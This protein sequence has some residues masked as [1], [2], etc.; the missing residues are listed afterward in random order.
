M[1]CCLALS[2]K[3][4]LCNNYA[5]LRGLTCQQHIGFFDDPG[6]IK[7]SWFLARGYAHYLHLSTWTMKWIESCLAE[8][9]VKITREDIQTLQRGGTTAYFL[10]LVARH[11]EG[12]SYSWN[13]RLWEKTVRILWQWSRRIGAV[14]ITNKDLQILLCVKGSILEFYK[15]IEMAQNELN[16]EDFFMFVEDCSLQCPEWFEYFIAIPFEEHQKLVACNAITT[17]VRYTAWILTKKKRILEKYSAKSS[18]TKHEL[19]A[20]TWHPE[21]F[22]KWVFSSE[23]LNELNERWNLQPPQTTVSLKSVL[24]DVIKN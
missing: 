1:S 2:K 24:E 15:G 10:L 18:I 9:L 16:E 8:G 3:R 4:K 20:V 21:R 11:V 13:P 19:L 5:S 17:K 22:R 23:E 14:Q 6:L 12:F 7:R